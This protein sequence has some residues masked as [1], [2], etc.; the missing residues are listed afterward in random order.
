MKKTIT[1]FLALLAITASLASADIV[2]D[3]PYTESFEN[4]FGDWSFYTKRYISPSGSVTSWWD[5][6]TITNTTV[7]NFPFTGPDSA[8]DGNYYIQAEGGKME[9]E[10]PD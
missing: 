8:F 1:L 7:A 2:S 10:K 6:W 5:Q 3:F 4:T 9:W